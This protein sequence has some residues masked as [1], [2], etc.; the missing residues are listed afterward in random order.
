MIYPKFLNKNSKIAVTAPSD[1]ITDKLKINCFKNG[2]KM[3]KE[4]YGYDV[5]FTDNVFSSLNNGRSSTGF[6]RAMEFNFLFESNQYDWIISATGGSYLVEM[7]NYVNFNLIEKNPVYVQGYS[8]NTSLLYIITTKCDVATIYGSNFGAFGMEKYG[9]PQEQYLD[10][11]QG[12]TN[13]VKSFPMY[14]DKFRESVTG[15][16][17]YDLTKK[18]YWVNGRDENRISIKG[19][20]IGGCSDVIFSLVGTRYDYTSKFINKYKNEGIIFYF[21]SFNTNQDDLYLHLWQLK[22]SNYFKFCNGIIF[23]RP[24][25]Y[26]GELSYK[27]VCLD[28]LQDLNIP[29]IFDADIGHKGPQIPIINGALAKV[30]SENGQGIIEYTFK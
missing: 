4:K 21:E 5:T 16:E 26:N 23:G 10:L 6:E 25:F 8:D 11:L 9:Q 27:S 29:I 15:L 3:L 30:T 18:T 22:E 17:Y 13:I 20:L 12:K 24:L 28:V 14:E 1:G 19:R 7:L 2:Q